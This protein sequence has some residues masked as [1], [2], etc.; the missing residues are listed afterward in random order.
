M[1]LEGYARRKLSLG[2]NRLKVKRELVSLLKTYKNLESKRLKT[3]AEAVIEEVEKSSNAKGKLIDFYRSNVTMGEMGVGSRGSGDFFVHRQIA[4][5]VGAKKK[6]YV[7]PL[8]QDDAGV[9]RYKGANIVLAID[10][11][12]SRLSDFPFLAGFHVARASAR[13]VYVMGA[14]PKAFFADLHLADDGDVSK[15]FDFMAGVGVVSSHLNAP[16]LSGSTL[17]VGGDMVIGE[18]MVSG[19]G[20]IGIAKTIWAR[21]FAQVGDVILMTRGAGGGTITTAAIYSGHYD[22]V[23]E[24]INLDFAHAAQALLNSRVTI[25]SATDVTNGGLRGDCFEIA[26]SANVKINL[27]R[28]AIGRLVNRRV[29]AMLRELEIDHLGVSLD[30]LLV[31]C[32]PSSEKKIKAVMKKK[33][34]DIEK[35]GYVEESKAPQV[36]LDGEKVTPRFRESAY[37]KIKKV[38]GETT[39]EQYGE[40]K[41]GV[42]LAQ[43]K[44]FQKMGQVE[45]LL[46]KR[47]RGRLHRDR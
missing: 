21:R 38:Y 29:G 3:I 27:F 37:T 24:T 18:R 35:I 9:I 39:P 22:V 28:D 23:R 16:V 1:D 33:G 17:R 44:A 14:R 41:K 8:D 4:K 31:I 20:C 36:T 6:A 45:G 47:N 32:P 5:L 30:A 26:H 46:E 19:V 42:A 43:K 7:S 34:I 40:M 15:L 25:H 13:D 11:T 2:E 12:H 10:G